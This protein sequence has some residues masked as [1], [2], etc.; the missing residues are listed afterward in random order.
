MREAIAG[1]AITPLQVAEMSGQQS[2]C[3]APD[4]IGFSGHFPD[5][6]ILPAVLQVLMAQLIAEE[7]VNQPLRV[8]AL[9]RAKFIRQIRPEEK[10]DVCVDCRELDDNLRCAVTLHVGTE[11]AAS[12]SLTLSRGLV[13]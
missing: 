8:I 2:F 3:F 5:Y 9:A 1:A 13:S 4:F 10:I 6:P 11:Q 12:F 7:I